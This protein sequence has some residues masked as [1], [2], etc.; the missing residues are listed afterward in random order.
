VIEDKYTYKLD[1]I[2]DNLNE[3]KIL[4][5]KLLQILDKVDKEK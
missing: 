1:K 5:N 4:L 2:N 3:I